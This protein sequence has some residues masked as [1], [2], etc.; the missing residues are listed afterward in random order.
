[1]SADR[2]R[3]RIYPHPC[4]NTEAAVGTQCVI[5]LKVTPFPHLATYTALNL[6]VWDILHFK[7]EGCMDLLPFS[8]KQ[9]RYGELHD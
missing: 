3:L 4:L 9:L 8:L 5:R 1:M 7:D 6:E 2:E